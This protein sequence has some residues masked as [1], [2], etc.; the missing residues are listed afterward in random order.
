MP[1]VA[2][3]SDVLV[4]Q[5]FDG[6]PSR[7]QYIE[8]AQLVAKLIRQRLTDKAIRI[9]LDFEFPAISFVENDSHDL[10]AGVRLHVWFRYFNGKRE[11]APTLGFSYPCYVNDDRGSHPAEGTFMINNVEIPCLG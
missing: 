7:F 8:N 11:D 10:L 9:Q 6:L 1:R 2:L 5:I 3:E 4:K